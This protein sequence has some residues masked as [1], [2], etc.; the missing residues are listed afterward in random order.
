MEILW[1]R[2]DIHGKLWR[3]VLL[4]SFHFEDNERDQRT[5]LT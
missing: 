5:T 1:G 2:K 4:E 3:E